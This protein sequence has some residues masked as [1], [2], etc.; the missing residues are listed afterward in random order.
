MNYNI[1]INSND[2]ISG[3]HNNATFQINWDIIYILQFKNN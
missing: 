1:Y 3:K 2:K